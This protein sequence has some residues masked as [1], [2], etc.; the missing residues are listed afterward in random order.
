MDDKV[1]AFYLGRYNC[2][3]RLGHSPLGE[4]F[5]AKI[6]GV[7]G[8]EKQFAVKRLHAA[9]SSDEEFIGRFVNAATA[10]AGLDHDR[11]AR[12]HEVNV[13]GAQYYVAV[14]L[15]RGVDLSR[16]LELLRQRG[17]ALPT[18]VSLLLALDLA[19]GLEYAHARRDLLPGG[20]LHLG[21]CPGSVMVTQEGDSK[22]LD[23]G[24]LAAMVRL[25]WADNDALLP[26]LSYL[27]PEQL[28][29]EVCEARADVFSLGAILYE[30]VSGQLAFPGDTA[31]Q[32]RQRV[33]NAPPVPPSSDARLQAI[34]TGALQADA[35]A[36]PTMGALREA[37][38]P[39]LGS[40]TGRAR[41]ELSTIMRRVTRPP[42]RTGTFP[43]VAMASQTAPPPSIGPE[44]PW[45]PPSTKPRSP[46]PPPVP[47]G[48]RLQAP[49]ANTLSGLGADDALLAPL[50][51]IE[52]PGLPTMRDMAAVGHNGDE[53]VPTPKID[54]EHHATERVTKLALV[55]EEP[56]GLHAL[57]MI[58]DYDEDTDHAAPPL[59][60]APP[61]PPRDPI[62][63]PT[64]LPPVPIPE[65]QFEIT[66]DFT[67]PGPV[68]PAASRPVGTETSPMLPALAPTDVDEGAFNEPVPRTF[69]V[70]PL[71]PRPSRAPLI[72]VAVFGVLAAGG[73]GAWFLL[74]REP[75]ANPPVAVKPENAEPAVVAKPEN[76]EPTKPVAVQPEPAKPEPVAVKPE[77]AKPEPVAVKPEP[78]KPEPVAVKP[79]PAK[80][81]PVAVKPEPVK[82]EPVAKTAAPGKV[83]ITSSPAG[84]VVFVDG[85]RRGETPL[86]LSLDGEHRV[87]VAAEGKKLRKETVR[88]PQALDLQL[89]PATGLSGSGGLKV[90]CKTTGALRI[91][92]DGVD[93]GHNCPND[94]R[95]SV[96]P[97]PHK[98]GLY[99][100]LDDKTH[101]VDA[102]VQS[103]EGS[104]RLYL[105]L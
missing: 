83:K 98:V 53:T 4:T 41:A 56:S 90:R 81:E 94:Q 28:R 7:A 10:Y 75:N 88:A 3:E 42:S 52:V 46:S 49:S 85:T 39:L 87:V 65:Q 101:D 103:S 5:R 74:A 38:V 30:L 24:L 26:T 54:D 36:R 19:E 77:P 27:S 55:G 21:L 51:I 64:P 63:G 50:E 17:E 60:K 73:V 99:N 43:V 82:P 6:Y 84:A 40:R 22:L 80:P 48:P 102:D 96:A 57:A 59:M 25:G 62:T 1:K 34:I 67:N 31:R 72:A 14:D 79:E 93:S 44:R 16:L 89:E 11:V 8:F 9:L 23:V 68:P 20:V 104:T 45:A 92:V 61:A 97:G 35:D 78:A 71:R 95:I 70:A 58:A 76:P 86:E 47:R 15:V 37:L 18:D 69:V 13:Q 66:A 32:V 91:F 105:K 29:G 2:V 33:E 100:P 12:V